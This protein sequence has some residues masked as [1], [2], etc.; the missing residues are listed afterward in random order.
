MRTGIDFILRHGALLRLLARQAALR[1]GAMAGRSDYLRFIVVTRTRTGWHLLRSALNTHSQ[2]VVLGELFKNP[3]T[4]V[5]RNWPYHYVPAWYGR[6]LSALIR[7]DPIRFLETKVFC[8]YP[9]AVR[10]VGFKIGYRHARESQWTPVWPYLQER[11]GLKV[12]HLKRRNILKAHLSL[13]RAQESRLW[14]SRSGDADPVRPVHLDIEKCLSAFEETRADGI[15][16]DRFFDGHERTDVF[17]ED[18][19]DSY[20]AEIDRIQAFLGVR[21]ETIEPKTRRLGTRPLSESIEN[22]GEL[23]R[24][25]TDTPWEAFLHER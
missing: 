21:S 16:C 11:K 2:V 6:R 20:P 17:Y 22:Y 9:A 15:A 4:T 23:V 10:A 24:R 12:I 5:L 25:F 13:V 19:C 8:T 14:V 18:L 3:E 7:S 1:T